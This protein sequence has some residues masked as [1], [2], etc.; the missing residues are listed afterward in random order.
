MYI[1]VHSV[2]QN[3]FS[4]DH[5]MLFLEELVVWHQRKLSLN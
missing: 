2:M 4:R 1:S 3:A 5:L